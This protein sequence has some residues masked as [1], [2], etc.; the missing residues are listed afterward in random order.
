MHRFVRKGSKGIALIDQSGDRPRLKYVFDYAD[1]IDGRYNARKP[2]VWEM[3]PEHERSVIEAIDKSYEIDSFMGWDGI[4]GTALIGHEVGDVIFSLAHSLAAR[5]YED[6]KLD[7]GYST[8]DSFLEDYDEYNISVAFRDA[9]TVSTAYCIMTRCGIDPSDYIYDEDFQ[10]IFDFNTPA[11]VNALGKTT[12]I[13]SQEVLREIE[14]TIKTYE[15]TKTA[16]RSASHERTDIHT[17]RG[18][19]DTRHSDSGE[20]SA[21]Q[22]RHDAEILSQGTP[23][24]D[25]QPAG[26]DGKIVS[27]LSGGRGYGERE[28]GVDD[29]S[30][31]SAVTTSGQSER[32]DGLG[33]AYEWP[34]STGGGNDPERAD[35]QLNSDETTEAPSDMGGVSASS[36]QIS[37]FPTEHEQV[38]AIRQAEQFTLLS[39]PVVITQE[40]MDNAIIAWNGDPASVQRVVEYMGVNARSREAAAFLQNEYGKA[41]FTVT[42][43]GA[44]PLTMPWHKVQR[45]I[46]QI[47]EAGRFVAPEPE[48]VPEPIAVPEATDVTEPEPEMTSPSPIFLPDKNAVYDLDLSLYEGGAILGYDKNGVEYSVMHMGERNFIS[49]TTKITPMGDILGADGIHAPH[50]CFPTA[51]L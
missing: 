26:V 36:E 34:E 24:D 47:I 39:I 11:T 14:V 29:E 38:T 3:K 17:E 49:T 43:D 35:L 21:D 13:L 19:S 46:A 7:I 12:S 50:F 45:G 16:K 48:K 8:P 5:Y 1:T 30:V 31:D 6:N 28:I 51:F 25:L 41:E 2:F 4:N 22:V 18:L 37:L 44:E 23:P 40:D 42:K 27:V 9:L 15:R 32:P 10:P 20:P 33:G